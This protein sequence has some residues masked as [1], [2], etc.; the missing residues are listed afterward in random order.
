MNKNTFITAIVVGIIASIAFIL[1]QPIFGIA[2]LTSRHADAYVTL[3]AYSECTAL[4]LSWFVH[5]SVSIFYAVL[6][7][8]IFNI[9]SSSIANVGQVL[10]LGWITTLTATPANEWVVKLITTEQIPAFSSLSAL[11]TSVGPKLWLHILFFAF[12][13]VGLIFAKSNQQQDTFID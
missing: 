1:V 8:V 3:G 5:V 12:I 2:T 9:N 11:N 10:V 6:S 4:V 13:V 7:S